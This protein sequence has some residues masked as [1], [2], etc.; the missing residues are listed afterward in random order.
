MTSDDGGAK[1]ASAVRSANNGSARP[2]SC[3]PVRQNA[4]AVGTAIRSVG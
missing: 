1:C 2:G 4:S 3:G